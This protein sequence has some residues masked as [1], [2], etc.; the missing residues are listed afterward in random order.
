MTDTIFIAFGNSDRCGYCRNLKSFILGN[1]LESKSQRTTHKRKITGR[2]VY[3]DETSNIKKTSKQIGNLDE[4]G[5]VHKKLNLKFLN[6]LLRKEDSDFLYIPKI[7]EVDKHKMEIVRRPDDLDSELV[8]TE[9][10]TL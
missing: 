2:I 10:Q 8:I 3:Y 6:R 5:D 9:L 4:V 1:H 7:F